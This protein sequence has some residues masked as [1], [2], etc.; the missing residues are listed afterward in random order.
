MLTVFA[1]AVAKRKGR[2]IPCLIETT[3][4]SQIPAPGSRHSTRRTGQPSNDRKAERSKLSFED[5]I[6]QSLNDLLK[7]LG[8]WPKGLVFDRGFGSYRILSHLHNAGA[9]FFVRLKAGRLIEFN[10][11]RIEVEHLKNDDETIYLENPKHR[12]EY[13]KLRVVRSPK[14]RRAKEPW[15][16]ITNNFELSRERI[17]KIYYHRFEIEEMFKDIKHLW[18]FKHARINKPAHLKVILWFISIGMALIYIVRPPVTEREQKLIHPKQRI[19]WL[20]KGW[21][22]IQRTRN[23]FGLYG[24][25]E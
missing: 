15:Y 16:I 20:R 25:G 11:E 4:A 2:P 9:T 24:V 21:E 7:R 19:P 8:F 1:G 10:G 3:Y 5:H 18:E 13:I 23:W 17:V 12:G 6:L 22:E 14:S